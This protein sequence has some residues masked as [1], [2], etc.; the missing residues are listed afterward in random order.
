MGTNKGQ[1]QIEPFNRGEGTDIK[2]F[3]MEEYKSTLVDLFYINLI[4]NISS[5]DQLKNV[6]ATTTQA[7]VTELS[8]Q[9][10]PTYSLMQ[11]E[12]LEPIVM[13][14]FY[15]L[16]KANYF[17]L[18]QISILKEDPRIKIRFY[19]ALTIAQEQDDQE[20]ANMYFQT[21]ASVL[22]GMVAANNVNAVEFIDAA[23]KRFRVKALEFK[24]GEETEKQTEKT[25]N[26][27]SQ[28][29]GDIA[30]QAQVENKGVIGQ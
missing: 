14:V 19:N 6:T 21:I 17:D 26:Q 30:M 3:E 15:C 25:I 7:L 20:R 4:E 2:F 10:E 13:K 11:K 27:M 1:T 16:T 12:M 24:S 9:I 29:Q 8:R 23:Q 22:G 5:V 18:T 28:E